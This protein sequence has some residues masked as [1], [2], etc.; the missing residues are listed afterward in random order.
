MKIIYTLIKT[1]GPPSIGLIGLIVYGTLAFS[2][3]EKINYFDS[4]Y[5]T[6]TVL[7]TVGFGDI[8]PSTL[9]RKIIFMSLVL[10]GLFII[11]LFHNSNYLFYN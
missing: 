3:F 6:I 5:W 11:W 9:P 8:T 10:F 2:Y 4:L 7:S 1:I